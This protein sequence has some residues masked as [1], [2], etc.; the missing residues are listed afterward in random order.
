MAIQFP[1]IDPVL[2]QIGPLAIRWY[3]LAYIAGVVLGWI[4]VKK[5]LKKH[6]LPGLEAAR[7]D[8]M[9]VWAISGIILGGRL[10]YTLF[11]KPEYY[12][13][14]PLEILH[15]WQGG[16]SFHGG[17][18]G[19]ALAFYLFCRK[20]KIPYLRLMDLMACVVPIGL[21]F[22]RLANFINGELWGRETKVPW[23]VVFPHA[24]I[25]PRHP[26]Q[27][28]E[29][30]LEGAVLMAL[31]LWLLNHTRLRESPGA[32]CGIFLIGYGTARIICEFFREPDVQ[33]GFLW[34]GATMGQLLSVPMIIFGTALFAWAKKRHAA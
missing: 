8:D 22:G 23:A 10:G 3:S 6:P 21:G 32:L 29:A 9:I 4:L 16:M 27:L 30:A 34:A 12:L 18:I 14:N 1:H 28:Y 2:V 7:I 31:L 33:L 5:Q 20:Y 25:L 19:F 17:A 11:Y 13:S 26:S 24:D 15:V